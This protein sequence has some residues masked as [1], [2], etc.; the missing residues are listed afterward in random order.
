MDR[1]VDDNGIDGDSRSD[2]LAYRSVS[3]LAVVGFVLSITSIVAFTS[4]TLW[5]APLVAAFVSW[6]GIRSVAKDRE[7]KTGMTIAMLGLAIS[8]ATFAAVTARDYMA[9][10]LHRSEAARVADQFL[11]LLAEGDA[12]GAIELTVPLSER[13]PSRELAGIYYD[14]NDTAAETLA[15]FLD[16]KVVVSLTASDAPK[17]RLAAGGTPF[18]QRGRRFG[19]VRWYEL[20]D[21]PQG[22]SLKLSLERSSELAPGAVAWRITKFDFADRAN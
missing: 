16:T 13:R 7:T 10:H 19:L 2:E 4:S 12:I 1:P 5:V 15:K 11:L 18:K 14:S 17:V 21:D 9:D 22:R 8:V 6:L 20:L 3:S